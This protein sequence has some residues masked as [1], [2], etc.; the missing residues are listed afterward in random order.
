M[1]NER[2]E[3]ALGSPRKTPGPAPAPA[4]S[5]AHPGAPR[6]APPALRP[7]TAACRRSAAR[8]SLPPASP[9][10]LLRP[11]RLLPAASSPLRRRQLRPGAEPCAGAARGLARAKGAQRLCTATSCS[12]GKRTLPLLQPGLPSKNKR[13][14][15]PLQP[16]T[17]AGPRPGRWTSFPWLSPSSGAGNSSH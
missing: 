8:A 2:E 17:A 12:P 16:G 1:K 5:P 9:G 3:P 13:A 10:S 7:G 4:A 11:R 6:P 15:C 14:Q